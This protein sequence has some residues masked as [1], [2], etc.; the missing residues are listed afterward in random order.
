MELIVYVSMMPQEELKK[1]GITRI[2]G[3]GSG[4]VRNVVLQ[5]AVAKWYELPLDL[6]QSGDAALGAALANVF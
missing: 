3:N 6:G 1:I 2:V 4:L 5:I